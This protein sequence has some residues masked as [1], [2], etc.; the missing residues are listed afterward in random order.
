[1]IIQSDVKDYNIDITKKINSL[2]FPISD[3]QKTIIYET[4]KDNTNKYAI[5]IINY[6]IIDNIR[7]GYMKLIDIQTNQIN[8]RKLKKKLKMI[9]KIKKR[10]DDEISVIEIKR[11]ITNTK[12]WND[13]LYKDDIVYIITE[14]SLDLNNKYSFYRWNLLG[15]GS[16]AKVYKGLMNNKTHIA[17]KLI[18]LNVNTNIRDKKAIE[19]EIKMMT[20]IKNN[21]HPNIITCYDII[22]SKDYTCIIFN[23]YRCFNPCAN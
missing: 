20:I 2:R 8:I 14:Y 5:K 11:N 22:R 18:D 16:F 12:E 21:P 15:K 3:K 4:F 23:L 1:M 9:N 7:D 17:I 6:S 13:I 19:E 10:I